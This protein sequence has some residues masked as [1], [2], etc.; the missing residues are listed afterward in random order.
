MK[1]LYASE[2]KYCYLMKEDEANE[3]QHYRLNKQKLKI[4]KQTKAIEIHDQD[5]PLRT[6][7][8]HNHMIFSLISLVIFENFLS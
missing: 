7:S 1:N 6:P 4:D 3:K 8:I 5:L 2:L